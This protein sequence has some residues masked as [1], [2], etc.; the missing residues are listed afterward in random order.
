MMVCPRLSTTWFARL[1]RQA[2]VDGGDRRTVL[3]F[4]AFMKKAGIR[5]TTPPAS[6]FDDEEEDGWDP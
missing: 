2:Q 3:H 5:P 1:S 6:I 4:K